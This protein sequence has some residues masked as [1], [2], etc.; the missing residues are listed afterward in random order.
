MSKI[1]SIWT[2]RIQSIMPELAIEQIELNQEGV[3]NDI[4][5]VNHKL[6]F[7]FTKTQ[8]YFGLLDI[9]MGLLDIIRPH[10]SV[11]IPEPILKERGLVVYPL[12]EGQPL[13]FENILDL[14]VERQQNL[15]D[16]I[17]TFLHELHSIPLT[18]LTASLPATRAYVKREDWIEF[19]KSFREKVYLLLQQ[20][21]I[22]WI[23]RL[24]DKV[25]GDPDFFNYSPVL[26]H[27]DLAPYHILYSP[28][29]SR[30]CGVID[31]GMAGLGDPASD[32]GILI[33]IYGENFLHKMQNSYPDLEKLMHR[34]RF[35]AQSIEL[36]WS[37]R[38]I[39]SG[40]NF[41]FTAHLGCARDIRL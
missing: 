25:F 27:G 11:Q 17:G 9:E 28:R 26:I 36:E 30:I 4:V 3:I 34:A 40:K 35:Y 13:L 32:F 8:E 38:G 14:D 37:L 10:L 21:Q 31:F 2:D 41:W 24:F 18:G 15:A 6:V 20:N 7:R 39:E 22:H 5:I 19:R 23:E 29:D 12:L 16:Q 1:D 33:S